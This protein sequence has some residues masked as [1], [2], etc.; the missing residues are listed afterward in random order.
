MS[1]FFLSL[2]ILF[3]SIFSIN[4]LAQT[5]LALPDNF[6]DETIGG[7]DWYRPIGIT[8]DANGQIYVWE[9]RG[10]VSIIDKDGHKLP[11]LNIQEEVLNEADH[12]LV[13]FTLDP[14]FLLNGYIYLLYVV[15]PHHLYFFGTPEY[16]PNFS[17]EH[18]ATIGRITRYTADA[19]TGF[20]TIIDG[21]RKVILGKTKES[22]FPILM[23]SHGVGSLVFGADGSL[24]ASC[25]DGG[26]YE[27]IDTGSAPSDESYWE[28]GLQEGI[29]K[30]NDNVGSFKAQQTHNLNGT[31][32]RIHPETGQGLPGNPFYEASSPDA[33]QSKV[34]ALG[35]RNPYRFIRIP[36]TGSHNP[37][38][39]DPGVLVV[40]DVGSSRWEELNVVLEG[41]QNFGWP[42][43]EGLGNHNG[44]LAAETENPYTPNPE[45]NCGRQSFFFQELIQ[46]PNA[47][48]L[49]PFTS[50]CLSEEIIPEQIRTFSHTPPALAWT[51]FWNPPPRTRKPVYHSDTGELLHI[52]I[53][54]SESDIESP[55][56]KGITSIPGAFYEGGSFPEEYH[57][58]YFHA[59]LSG[60]LRVLRFDNNYSVTKIDT[61]AIWDDRGVVHVA[62]N[63]HDGALYWCDVYQSKIHRI[64]YGGNPRPVALFQADRQ[65]GPGPL[66]IQ[67]N[68]AESYDPDGSDITFL[69]DFGDGSSST[70]INP[71]H[72]FAASGSGPASFSVQ[73]TVTDTAGLTD[74]KAMIISVNNTPPS[75]AI[76]SF[77]D[78]DHYP[79]NGLTYLPLEAEVSDAEHSDSEL[80]YLWESF[81]H[82]NNHYHP[83]E[84][85]EDHSSHV[86]LDPLGCQFETYW[87]RVRLTVRDAHGLEAYDE[88][89][90]FP[91]CEPDFFELNDLTGAIRNEQT[92]LSWST[93]LEEDVASFI[94]ER[95][96]DYRF[97]PIGTV[98]GSGN[99]SASN[100][101]N[102]IDPAPL[103]GGNY[104][105]LKI[106]N[107]A[108]DYL[109]SN[110][111]FVDYS[112]IK[113]YLVY[114]NPT[115]GRSE[116]LINSPEA[117]EVRIDLF[118]VQGIPIYKAQWMPTVGAIFRG[119]LELEHLPPG[120]YYYRLRHGDTEKSGSLLRIP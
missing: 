26:S 82:H 41:G 106:L 69:W 78:G 94:I 38:S 66:D 15:D 32:I 90:V 79:V 16:D 63:P 43:F 4:L 114:P 75:V 89:E 104:Y 54:S 86:I 7:N 108:G 20:T 30:P 119:E 48:Q 27:S 85:I 71:S 102:F 40:G 111:V 88:R 62:Y 13:G 55:G 67:F 113:D 33:P 45:S 118:T 8:F 116:V 74:T 31:I 3:F 73:L 19:N 117:K 87:Y 98:A 52:D 60:W 18:E 2:I 10:I 23:S 68:G 34:W 59:D 17:A 11:L 44:F 77:K 21:S 1:R 91:F 80:S 95:T 96:A 12:G 72:T 83:N 99:S 36:N 115:S 109:Y 9:K 93:R 65:Y 58:A 105:R 28:Q 57:G 100:A 51:S 37:E 35:L 81:L 49:P 92:H 107:S 6:Y 64:S 112:G 29:I 56:F 84:P 47:I 103:V 97:A 76:S 53:G 101:Y 24:L 120:L 39:G 46:Q 14:Q 50:P 25:G 22:G 42:I 110:V 5:S 61:F 70:D